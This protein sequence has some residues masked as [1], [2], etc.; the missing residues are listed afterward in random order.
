[1]DQ[2]Y[3]LI[4]CTCPDEVVA[5][6]LAEKLVSRHLA[7]C[8]NLLPGITSIYSWQGKLEADSEVMLVIKSGVKAYSAVENL[9]VELHP[10][11]LP[12]IVAVPIQH[13]SPEYLNWISQCLK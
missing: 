1:M 10:Y 2:E 6:Q 11:E 7:A 5:K 4:L 9:I 13:G 12:E 8:V 3:C